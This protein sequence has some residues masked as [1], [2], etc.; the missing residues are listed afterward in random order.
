M[1]CIWKNSIQPRRFTL[2]CVNKPISAQL[3]SFVFGK[4]RLCVCC[5]HTT[6]MM[7]NLEIQLEDSYFRSQ[8]LVSKIDGLIETSIA[9][10]DPLDESL[11]PWN[12]VRNGSTPAKSK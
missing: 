10:T 6:V 4:E 11:I 12:I 5:N 1:G 7:E 8:H 9:N 3:A 2:R